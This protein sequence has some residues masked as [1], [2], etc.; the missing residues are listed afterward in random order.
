MPTEVQFFEKEWNEITEMMNREFGE[1]GWDRKGIK[2]TRLK[3][4]FDENST[5]VKN[6]VVLVRRVIFPDGD[7][8]TITVER[9]G[10]SFFN[11]EGKGVIKRV[12]NDE[13]NHSIYLDER[14]NDEKRIIYVLQNKNEGEYP[15]K[16][17]ELQKRVKKGLR[18]V[19]Q[20]QP[21]IDG[22]INQYQ[23]V[24]RQP[25]Y[26]KSK[27]G[28]AINQSYSEVGVERGLLCEPVA[29]RRRATVE[30]H[31]V[32]EF[33]Y[34]KGSDLF[35]HLF[36]S[37]N[38]LCNE[39]KEQIALLA[40]IDLLKL[41][42]AG[43]IH[44]DI[45][46]ENICLD[47]DRNGKWRLTIIDL[48]DV[49]QAEEG[50]DFYDGSKLIGTTEY[51]PPE[52]FVPR[53]DGSLI[54]RD[55]KVRLGDNVKRKIQIAEGKIRYTQA[56]DVFSLGETLGELEISDL[57]PTGRE[58]NEFIRRMGSYSPESRP[59]LRGF[60]GLVSTQ[61]QVDEILEDRAARLEFLRNILSSSNP[62][63]SAVSDEY[64]EFDDD[65]PLPPP[66]D[67][68]DEFDDDNDLLPPPSFPHFLSEDAVIK[69]GDVLDEDPARTTQTTVT[70]EPSDGEISPEIVEQDDGKNEE[71]VPVVSVS[72]C[73][74]SFF[75]WR[76]SAESKPDSNAQHHYCH[77]M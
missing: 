70:D 71:S 66:L 20:R 39:D 11:K 53:Q 3:T 21:D 8:R 17:T 30:R 52:L 25:V 50:E 44:R 23:I 54:D 9:T 68:A 72:S 75:T 41:H 61:E 5:E 18:C 6:E 46:P 51:L 2:I 47:K 45:K 24:E 32:Y 36:E 1:N 40:I 13:N 29:V 38:S 49:C 10:V 31:K 22:D 73:M 12:E 28:T 26:Y 27:P 34:D 33:L 62:S 42:A 64:D 48:A 7:V 58:L 63:A 57:S 35:A 60:I 67:E 15:L 16:D 74:S 59:Q 69:D 55:Y 37:E 4:D 14:T 56:G 43:M 76:T 65:L 19:V 77:I